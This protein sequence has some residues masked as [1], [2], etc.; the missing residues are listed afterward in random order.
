MPSLLCNIPHLIIE[1]ACLVI[2]LVVPVAIVRKRLESGQDKKGIGVRLIQFL[3]L[4]LVVPTLL[5]LKL[6]EKI[7]SE[8]LMA[9][10]GT[11]VGYVLSNIEKFRSRQ[12]KNSGG[13]I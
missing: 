2:M 10:L 1:I 8:S 5:I 9:L 4:S 6:E 3:T 12:S 7:S 13:S 11:L